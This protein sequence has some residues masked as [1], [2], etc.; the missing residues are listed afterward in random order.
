MG[1]PVLMWALL[2]AAAIALVVWPPVRFHRYEAGKPPAS[3]SANSSAGKGTSLGPADAA[4]RFWSEQ[5]TPLAAK[6]A[7]A[8]EVIAALRSDA[9]GARK[10]YARTPAIGG[11][12]YFFVTGEGK[13]VSK[14]PKAVGVELDGS[15][16]P[17]KADVVVNV[18][19]LFG[20]AVRDGTGAFAQ[21]DFATSSDFNALSGELNG[22]VKANV[23]P[24]LREKAEV[25]TH[26][27]ITGVAEV[28]PDDESPL[29]LKLVPL[30]V[31]FK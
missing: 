23:F 11:P 9:A 5:L 12:S 1:R 8:R 13:I 18:G 4:Q 28:S 6:A 19:P 7:D 20:N 22:R 26:L 3:S 29:P 30:L 14:E 10:R 21:G 16:T 2:L 24:P 25:G 31:E 27:H 15:P 17:G